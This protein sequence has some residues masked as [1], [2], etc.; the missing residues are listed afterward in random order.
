[1]IIGDGELN[2]GN[3]WEAIMFAAKYKLGNLVAIVDRNNIQLSGETEDIMPLENLSDKWKAFGWQVIEIDGNNVASI[4][5]ACATAR[6]ETAKPSAII[7]HTT[8]GKGVSFM[9]DD[10]HWHG[11]TPDIEQTKKAEEEL[12]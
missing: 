6:A 3:N 2:E 8:P 7:A 9:E 10:Y 1:M 11:K 5:D 12:R 4:I